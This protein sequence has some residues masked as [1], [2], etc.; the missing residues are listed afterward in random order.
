M[1]FSLLAGF[2]YIF[3]IFISVARKI[4]AA[5]RGASTR[6]GFDG[7]DPWAHP[8]RSVGGVDVGGQGRSAGGHGRWAGKTSMERACAIWSSKCPAFF[9][10]AV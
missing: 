10:V 2:F 4:V 7:S 6:Q 5:Q 9:L 8:R 3:Y 1:R